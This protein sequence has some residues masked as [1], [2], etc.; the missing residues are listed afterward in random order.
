MRSK[1]YVKQQIQKY[2]NDLP[3]FEEEVEASMSAEDKEELK[4]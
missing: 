4:E 1:E 2:R 3:A